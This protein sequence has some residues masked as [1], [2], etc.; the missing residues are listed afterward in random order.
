MVSAISRYDYLSNFRL[1][2]LMSL[3]LTTW[4]HRGGLAGYGQPQTIITVDPE[5]GDQYP[6]VVGTDA[7][8]Y[9]VIL[10]SSSVA[11]WQAGLISQ[12][13]NTAGGIF[14]ASTRYASPYGQGPGGGA[15]IT[16]AATPAGVGAGLNLS[17]NTLIITGLVAAVF[18]FGKGRR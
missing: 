9:P 12:A 2:G 10:D 5:T 4:H 11:P 13:I 3:N 14:G 6:V 16:T 18:L 7:N 1:G 8:G 15:T 17:T